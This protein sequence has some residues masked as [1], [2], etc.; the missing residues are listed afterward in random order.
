MRSQTNID[1]KVLKKVYEDP[2]GK[3]ALYEYTPTLFAPLYCNFEPL[4]IARRLRLLGEYLREGR[5]KVYYLSVDGVLVGYNILAPGGRRL[6][7]S[8]SRDIVSGPAVIDPDH[9][10][11]GYFKLLKPLCYLYCA[12][13]YE[14]VYNWV[15]KTNIP[16]IKA[17]ERM[18]FEIV[19]EVNTV[20]LRRKL[21][22]AKNG[23]CIVY[24]LPSLKKT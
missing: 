10:N 1:E 5:Y 20:G 2:M 24:R 22:P 17:Q 18:G 11:K 23:T 13:D 3:V 4:K 14:Y 12:Y 15:A 8:T 21:V 16:S 6:S 7:F 19:G 9:R